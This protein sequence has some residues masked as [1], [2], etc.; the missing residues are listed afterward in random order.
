MLKHFKIGDKTLQLVTLC[1]IIMC[2]QNLKTFSDIQNIIIVLLKND[3]LIESIV[4]PAGLQLVCPDQC[5][6][7]DETLDLVVWLL[8]IF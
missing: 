5:S 1:F 4:R 3:F 2:L 7:Q 8:D 6:V